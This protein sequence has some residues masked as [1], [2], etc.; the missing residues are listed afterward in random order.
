MRWVSYTRAVSCRKGEENPPDIISRQNKN[1]EAYMKELGFTVS[2]KYSDRKFSPEV[3]EGFDE[4]VQAGMRR[5]FDGVIIDSVFRCGK[6]LHAAIE[7]LHKTFYPVGIQFAVAEDHF[8]SIGKTADEVT[9]YFFEKRRL[10]AGDRMFEKLGYSEGDTALAYK[11]VRYGYKLS[12]DCRSLVAD[13]ESAAVVRRIYQEY[14]DGRGAGSI[15]TGLKSDGIPTPRSYAEWVFGIAESDSLQVKWNRSTVT[16]ILSS[17]VYAGDSTK[18]SKEKGFYV[19]VDRI[20]SEELY[21]KVQE[22]L[23]EQ[24]SQRGENKKI[25]NP[26]SRKIFDRDTGGKLMLIDS[27]SEPGQKIFSLKRFYKTVPDIAGVNAIRFVDALETVTDRLKQI[28]RQAQ[29]INT[30]IASGET[31]EY[32]EKVIAPYRVKAQ[33]LFA[34]MDA[35]SVRRMETYREYSAGKIDEKTYEDREQSYQNEL[36]EYEEQFR[37]LL[38]EFDLIRKVYSVKNP[39]VKLYRN[40]DLSDGVTKKVAAKYIA[41]V[42]VD[43]FAQVEIEPMEK[44]WRDRLPAEWFL[45]GG[46]EDGEKKQTE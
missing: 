7:I 14:A 4:L 45:E 8:C 16:K 3:S 18:V 39:W 6:A 23:A 17:S 31:K 20:I 22:L 43:G 41:A 15:A 1:I 25:L 29:A 35:V 10:R 2:K 13:P 19:S 21:E 5:E 34:A 44:E 24:S 37:P 32:E 26:L 36:S 38:E 46:A 40:M 42:Y 9:A 28:G 27:L 12:D 11:Q 30:K 33:E